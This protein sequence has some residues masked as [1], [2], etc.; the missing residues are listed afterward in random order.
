MK[1]KFILLIP[2][3]CALQITAQVVESDSITQNESVAE[4]DSIIVGV[5]RH[6]TETIIERTITTKTNSKKSSNNKSYSS[7]SVDI[8]KVTGDSVD[9]KFE[10][11]DLVDEVGPRIEVITPIISRG[12]KI[13][14]VNKLITVMGKVRMIVK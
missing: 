10:H 7:S 8:V 3:F 4:N 2:L 13:L 11:D 5:E 12:V 1:L 14:E 6:S 9:R